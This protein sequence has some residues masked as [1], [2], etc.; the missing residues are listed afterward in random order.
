[1]NDKLFNTATSTIVT[2]V[3]KELK[4][5]IGVVFAIIVCVIAVGYSVKGLS[6]VFLSLFVM[7]IMTA[8]QFY[9]VYMTRNPQTL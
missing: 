9:F 3:I 2:D 7:T 6:G 8:A 5:H 1:M 4:N